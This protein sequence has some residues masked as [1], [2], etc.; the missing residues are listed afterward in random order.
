MKEKKPFVANKN[1]FY[2]F[3][4][5]T[6][7]LFSIIMCLNIGFVARYVSTPFIYALGATSYLFY[8]ALNILGIRLIFFKKFLKVKVNMIFIATTILIISGLMFLT[9]FMT[10]DAF[11]GAYV[12][13]ASE[14]GKSINF[15]EGFQKV[16]KD[17]EYY[18][19]T[20]FLSLFSHPFAGGLLGYVLIA[21]FN[22]LFGIAN[23]GFI[24]AIVFAVLA[25]VFYFLPLILSLIG[26]NKA[27]VKK[28]EKETVSDTTAQAKQNQQKV[29][30]ID[31]VRHA[32][33]ID[34]DEYESEIIFCQVQFPS[35]L[36]PCL[37]T[38]LDREE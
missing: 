17:T 10:K 21:L 8:I 20:N 6:L 38:C 9:H 37:F 34:P 22:A 18:K 26:Q 14:S 28:E 4:G 29:K 11:G 27:P 36:C 24:I 7:V 19:N 2:I 3:F 12:A 16:I 31:V 15:F 23:G 35:H 1:H 5:L 25:L 32:S 13:L 30:N 33:E